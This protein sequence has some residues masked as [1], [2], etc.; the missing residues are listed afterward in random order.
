MESSDARP[1]PGGPVPGAA[2]A[3]VGQASGERGGEPASPPEV[4]VASRN[5]GKIA[6]LR[7]IVAEAGLPLRV[8][9]LE[10]YGGV[11][12]PAEVGATF[13]EN[14][15]L[16]AVAVAR[17]VGRPALAD[18]SGLCVDV[19][20][21]RPG[22]RSARYA[23]ES[24][25]DAANN[26]KLLA[27]MAGVPWP[28]RGAEFRCVVVLALPD[29]RWTAAEGRTRGKILTAPRGEAGF[30]YDPLFFSEELGMTFAE[31]GASAKNQVSHRGRALRALLPALRAWLIDGIVK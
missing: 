27:E 20:G 14:A 19:L 26:A 23:G 13:L 1:G 16:K 11:R 30:G 31:A 18:D 3:Q 10:Q 12:L 17:Q 24:A 9:D 4:V 22:V 29:G 7:Q 2:A 21:G 6:E 25:D 5:A 28:R 8:G 15:R